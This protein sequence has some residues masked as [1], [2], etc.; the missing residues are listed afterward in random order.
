MTAG[1]FGMI[2]ACLGDVSLDE[3]RKVD[4]RNVRILEETSW[5]AG[6]FWIP[7]DSELRPVGLTYRNENWPEWWR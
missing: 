2:S 6:S 7:D 4:K 3:G 1:T 5:A